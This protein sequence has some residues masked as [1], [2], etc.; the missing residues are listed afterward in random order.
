M[1]AR[2]SMNPP[3]LWPR[4]WWPLGRPVVSP[5]PV[6]GVSF[7]VSSSAVALAASPGSVAAG[8]G[9]APRLM[10]LAPSPESVAVSFAVAPA[11][12]SMEAL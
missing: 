12:V 6:V 7:A 9:A 10:A 4:N 1:S 11:A 2:W 5:P 3:L 8:F